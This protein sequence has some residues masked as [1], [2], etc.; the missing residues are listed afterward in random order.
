MTTRSRNSTRR[1]PK[2]SIP[3]RDG[4]VALLRS[5]PSRTLDIRREFEGHIAAR[6]AILAKLLEN[7]VTA[8]V[9]C[10]TGPGGGVDPHCSPGGSKGPGDGAIVDKNG[11]QLKVEHTAK[12]DD[13]GNTR[14]RF[15]VR[16]AEGR[17]IAYAELDRKAKTVSS[18]STVPEERRKGIAAALYAHI[19]KFLGYPL[20]ENWATTDEGAAF[21][22]GRRAKGFTANFNFLSWLKARLATTVLHTSLDVWRKLSERAWKKGV[23][24]AFND[25]KV[26]KLVD[27]TPSLKVTFDK[28]IAAARV[29]QLA[30][31]ADG[32]YTK[33]VQAAVPKIVQAF[34]EGQTPA[35]MA[36]LLDLPKARALSIVR[37]EVIRAHAEGQ[38]D[39][40]EELGLDQ[41]GV[42][43]E[44]HT[45]GDSRVCPLCRPMQGVVLKTSEA[46]GLLP[47]HPQCR[48]AFIPANVGEPV[49]G[50]KRT[51]GA[52][53]KALDKS[54]LE[55]E[56]DSTRPAVN[57]F[58][59]YMNNVF[60]ATGPGGGVDPT[61]SREPARMA[62]PTTP[63]EGLDRFNAIAKKVFGRD[64]GPAGAFIHQMP[65]GREIHVWLKPTF[66]IVKMEMKYD[67]RVD[68]AKQGS[69]ITSVNPTLEKESLTMLRKVRE[70]ATE[71][72]AAGFR[73]EVAAADQR[74]KELYAR[75]LQKLGLKLEKTGDIEV[76]NV[77]C[78]T[79]P[80]GGVDP[81]CGKHDLGW[82]AATHL[83]TPQGIAD[84]VK[85]MM[86]KDFKV[87]KLVH[88]KI[89]YLNPEGIKNG[90]FVMGL[91]T[92]WKQQM[93]VLQKILPKGTKIYGVDI[94]GHQMAAGITPDNKKYFGIS[95]G[96]GPTPPD[97]KPL[98]NIEDVKPTESKLGTGTV[99]AAP[100]GKFTPI[101]EVK[102]GSKVVLDNGQV[103]EVES[104][105]TSADGS[106]KLKVKGLSDPFQYSSTSHLEVVSAPAKHSSLTK[107]VHT[108]VGEIKPGSTVLFAGAHPTVVESVTTSAHGIVSIKYKGFDDP[109][110]YHVSTTLEVD[111]TV[112]S[113]H[114]P[115]APT[116]KHQVLASE[117]KIGDKVKLPDGNTGEVA[118]VTSADGYTLIKY[119]HSDSPTL[120]VSTF[121]VDVE[122]STPTPTPTPTP[123]PATKLTKYGE[124]TPGYSYKN[125]MGQ[126]K[127]VESVKAYGNA[128]EVK[129][130]GEEGS[131]FLH[132]DTPLPGQTV[133]HASV[134]PK[135][136]TPPVQIELPKTPAQDFSPHI[137]DYSHNEE[138]VK[139]AVKQLKDVDKDAK[140]S[141]R[142]Y[143]SSLFEDLNEQMRKCPPLFD[144]VKGSLKEH[145]DNI[146]GTIDKAAPF[147][148]PV[149]VKRGMH[150]EPLDLAKFIN[151]LSLMKDAST[152]FQFPSVTSTGQPF[153]GNVQFKIVAKRGLY[154]KSISHHEHEEEILVSPNQKFK[155][156]DVNP[157]Q[158]Y[159]GTY[160]VHLEEI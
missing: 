47:R 124:L 36:K 158:Y 155:V 136:W 80:G 9:F 126:T 45:A 76:W 112:P 149:F 135:A 144:C 125:T 7:Q 64:G 49:K 68:F 71:F 35:Q 69:E 141:I 46:R 39:G 14:H 108:P 102:P 57:A 104:I 81:T 33:S 86:P 146:V 51:K 91:S 132:K 3:R 56:I 154:V 84:Y 74:R 157:G 142:K 98:P 93:P 123:A 75:T 29:R 115:V 63:Q 78:A 43:V 11:R 23:V 110:T 32:Q 48:C 128:V 92:Q 101:A 1:W 87:V 21:W 73:L 106:A 62:P 4:G 90:V 52:I 94:K 28:P 40:F 19:E 18:V 118:S 130:V 53:V 88:D 100:K 143:T 26:L 119:K 67:V 66:D 41:V 13:A 151:G 120:H 60:C 83:H 138:F 37:T 42:Q 148:K 140:S 70:A 59:E 156:L 153:G 111:H 34:A 27:G 134:T 89:K 133:P 127:T 131:A 82:A 54:G 72:H 145:M 139:H 2:S 95:D 97:V 38:L 85:A 17:P 65:G 12:V 116:S 15:E 22:A 30:T 105:I 79:G 113:A 16:T 114:V 152:E 147:P 160:F 137:R 159:A 6:F 31:F 96:H 25:A 58:F 50:Q 99:A 10:P 61:C 129:F 109:F 103:H 5:D 44:W 150:L 77:F 8:N 122:K 20:Q 121:K 117:L 55:V 107:G 24:R